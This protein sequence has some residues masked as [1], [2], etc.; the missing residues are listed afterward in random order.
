MAAFQGRIHVAW[1]ESKPAPG[2]SRIQLARL[3]LE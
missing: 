2:Q 1:T 3:V